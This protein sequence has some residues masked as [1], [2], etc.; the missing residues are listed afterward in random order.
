[1]AGGPARGD[2]SEGGKQV[3]EHDMHSNGET[4]RERSDGTKR[5]RGPEKRPDRVTREKARAA[6]RAKKR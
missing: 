1:V 2:D 3:N 6:R 5:S 4:I